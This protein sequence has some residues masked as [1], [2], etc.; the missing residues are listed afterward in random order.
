[1]LNKLLKHELKATARLLIPLYLI[2]LFFTIMDRI[3]LHLDIFKGVLSLIPGLITIG[4]VLSIVAIVVVTAILMIMRFY[5]NL[6]TD[7]GYLMFTLPVKSYH[8]I[9][10]KL[11]VAI[12]WTVVSIIAVIGSIFIVAATPE[13]L[14]AFNEGL[15][16][17]WAELSGPSEDHRLTIFIELIL[18]LFL[19]LIN[20]ILL[21][22]L[23]IAIG[24][25]LN[26]HKI[27]GAFASYIG[28]TTVLQILATLLIF[29]ASLI[30]KD[31]V[32]DVT[33]IRTTVFPV[34][35]LSLII[36][37]VIYYFITDLIFKR[38][39]NLE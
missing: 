25:L 13:N 28:I 8:H 21:I 33:F 24:Q 5:K 14:K 20:N 39:L 32:E 22:Y 23:S 27:I 17:F 15:K 11:I 34:T 36:L 3:V 16:M 30:F 35:I 6:F 18:M 26:G 19:S 4:Y 1:M 10:S 37:S 9:N 2:L 7:E 12:L 38:K 31:I 29:A